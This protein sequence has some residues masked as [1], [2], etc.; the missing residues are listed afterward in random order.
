MLSSLVVFPLFALVRNIWNDRIAV[1]AVFL[2]A[3]GPRFVSVGSDTMTDGSFLFFF[4]S[5]VA[6]LWIGFRREK[7]W[8]G[9]VAGLFATASYLTRVEGVYLTA[10]LTVFALVAGTALARR[11]QTASL[12]ALAL[13]F[14]FF[15]PVHLASS[16]PYTLKIQE[17]TGERYFT[18]KNSVPGARV[19]LYNQPEKS[20]RVA[21]RIAHE[22]SAVNRVVV[23]KRSYGVFFGSSWAFFRDAVRSA[24]FLLPATRD[25]WTLAYLFS[26]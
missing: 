18:M 3:V 25:L 10:C 2:Y 5:A 17:L 4:V 9:A 8:M 11:R 1:L 23:W 22:A 7:P 15:I 24:E 6:L 20:S 16:A 14:V 13:V 26:G 12:R 21:E 19:P